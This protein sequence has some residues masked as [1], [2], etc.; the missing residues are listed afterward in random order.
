M[1]DAGT[2]PEGYLREYADEFASVEVDSTFYGTPQPE[3]VRK[4][5]AQVPAGFTFALKLPREITH[6]RRLMASRKLVEEFVAS[7]LEFEEKLEAI[8]IQ[9]APDFVPAEIEAVETF[10]R[11]LPRGPRWAFEV[12]DRDWFHGEAH[13]R[14]RDALG[15]NGVALAVSD[16][17]FIPLE[18]MLHELRRPTAS[19][20]YVRWLGTRASVA[21]FDELVIDRSAE[22][23]QW[24]EAIR[25][26]APQLTRLAGYANNQ[27]A[28]FSP[29]T[30]R[31][32]YTALGIPHERPKRIEQT[33][34]FD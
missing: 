12:R 33:S 18:T 28:G 7:A 32:L 13:G 11:E 21:R 9:C 15:T 1:Y 14:L 3:R 10:V 16:G 2:R 30:I 6:E 29:G 24:V 26:A 34:L 22:I 27:Y 19:H 8:L 20:A 5:A 31:M 25:D 4:W 17:P 23:T